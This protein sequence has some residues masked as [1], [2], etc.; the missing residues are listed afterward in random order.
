METKEW[1]AKA[2][3]IENKEDIEKLYNTEFAMNFL[4]VWTIFERINFDKFVKFEKIKDFSK[5]SFEMDDELEEIFKNFHSRYQEKEKRRQLCHK[6][7]CKNK[8]CNSFS[9]CEFKNLCNK[10]YKDIEKNEKIYFLTYI[11]YRYRNN[12]FH[13]SKGLESWLQFKEQ[14]KDCITVMKK[15]TVLP[16]EKDGEENG[17]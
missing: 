5:R 17:K 16:D 4:L 2:L 8:K 10:E 1:L 12:M 11:V 14:I 6:T 3:K 13:G 15:L 9:E 7:K